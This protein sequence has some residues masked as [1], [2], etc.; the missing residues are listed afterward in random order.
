ME[1][2]MKTM[3]GDARPVVK[4]AGGKRQLLHEIAPA[5]G[6]VE[7][8]YHEPFLGGAAVFLA[9]NP[10]RAVLNDANPRLMTV[11]RGIRDDAEAVCGMLDGYAKAYNGMDDYGRKEM[12]LD[13]RDMFNTPGEDDVAYASELMFLN[14][15]CF[16]GLYRENSKGGFNSPWG[17]QEEVRFDIDNIR[18]VSERLQDATL[19]CGDFADACADAKRGDTVFLDPPYDGTFDTYVGG[20]FGRQGQERVASLFGELAERGCRVVLTNSD[21]PLTRELYGGYDMK[22]LDVKRMINRD[23]SKRTGTEIMVTVNL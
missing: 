10:G 18:R 9:V 20:G 5:I 16:N 7:G 13:I 23:A 2:R 6:R 8:T 1:S 22:V 15:T 19:M 14:R 21:T 12:F 11:Y 4:W 17:K 3:D